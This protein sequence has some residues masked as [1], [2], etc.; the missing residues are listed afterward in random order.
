MKHDQSCNK[1]SCFQPPADDRLASN[2]GWLKTLPQRSDCW[3][4]QHAVQQ[5]LCMPVPSVRMLLPA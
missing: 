4:L 1:L 5:L 2:C 3:L